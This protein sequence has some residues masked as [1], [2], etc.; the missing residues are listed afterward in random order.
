MGQDYSYGEGRPSDLLVDLTLLELLET[1]DISLGKNGVLTK[2]RIKEGDWREKPS[3]AS[4]VQLYVES[5]SDGELP[6]HGFCGPKLLDFMVCNG[7][8]CDAL[9]FAS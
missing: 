2:K 7:D 9:E 1:I 5:A 4:R 6:L 8:V 3:E